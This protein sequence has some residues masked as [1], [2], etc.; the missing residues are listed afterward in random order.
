M[1]LVRA[2]CVD[3]LNPVPPVDWYTRLEVGGSFLR[4]VVDASACVELERRAVAVGLRERLVASGSA[5]VVGR[6]RRMVVE[7]VPV[8][9][10]VW[11]RVRVRVRMRVEREVSVG[12]G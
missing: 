8:D 5:S 7:V 12:R 10:W 9:V 2:V 3:W 4:F 1:I 6:G 11:V